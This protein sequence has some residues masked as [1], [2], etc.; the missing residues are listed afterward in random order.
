MEELIKLFKELLLKHGYRVLKGTPYCNQFVNKHESCEGC[1]SELGCEK[2]IEIYTA[3]LRVFEIKKNHPERL[4]DALLW[5]EEK[6]IY[7]LRGE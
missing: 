1:E 5:L 2:M 7:I 6:V 4:E 3:M